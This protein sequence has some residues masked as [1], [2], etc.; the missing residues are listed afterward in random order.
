MGIAKEEQA[1]SL[2]EQD[3]AMGNRMPNGAAKLKKL[4]LNHRRLIALVLQ[5]YSNN[6]IALVLTLTVSRVSIIRNAPLVQEVLSRHLDDCDQQ[7]SAL[8][9]AAVD[10]VKRGLDSG[11]PKDSLRAA[12]LL[13]KTQG[14]FKEGGEDKQNVT[15]EDVARQII[16]VKGEATITLESGRRITTAEGKDSEKNSLNTTEDT[17]DA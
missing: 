10:A 15:A 17:N 2:Y 9:P 12:D 13:F 11:N 1:L 7:L 6:D 5:G 8:L 14:K 4:N 16:E 3:K